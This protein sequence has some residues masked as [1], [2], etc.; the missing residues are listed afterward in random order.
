MPRRDFASLSA[1]EQQ[2]YWDWRARNRGNYRSGAPRKARRWWIGDVQTA[3]T[4]PAVCS[5]VT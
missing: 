4:L 1:Q 3:G 5:W 2:D